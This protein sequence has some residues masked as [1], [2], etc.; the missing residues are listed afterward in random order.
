MTSGGQTFSRITSEQIKK[1]L[2]SD[3]EQ[4]RQRINS[5]QNTLT[6]CWRI[7]TFSYIK[8]DK[9]IPAT[10]DILHNGNFGSEFAGL[11]NKNKTEVSYRNFCVSRL[12]NFIVS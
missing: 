4:T 7:T 12:L 3:R 8:S 9:L 1:K 5:R 11:F 10:I 2:L 6:D